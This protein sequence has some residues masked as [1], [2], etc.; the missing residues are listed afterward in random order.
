MWKSARLEFRIMSHLVDFMFVDVSLPAANTI[1]VSDAQGPGELLTGDH[2]GYGLVAADIDSSLSLEVWRSPVVPGRSVVKLDGSLGTKFPTRSSL[3]PTVPFAQLPK[4]LFDRTW[5]VLDRG[6]WS[7]SDHIT[8]GEARAFVKVVQALAALP[9]AHDHRVACLEDNTPTS[10]ALTK[11]RACAPAL[12]YLCRRKAASSLAAGLIVIAP[13]TQSALM[14]ADEA[15]RTADDAAD[16]HKLH[17]TAVPG[18]DY[19]GPHPRLV[20]PTVPQSP[21]PFP[22]LH[23]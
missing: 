2:G 14:L 21:D 23:P 22:R 1:F 6:R 5:H 19:R 16:V 20:Y 12:N 11:G 8:L 13:W 10:C 17:G 18:S 4:D 3:A 9:S 7:I 15:S